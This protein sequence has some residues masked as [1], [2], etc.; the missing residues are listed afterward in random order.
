MPVDPEEQKK[1][2]Y[3]EYQQKFNMASAEYNAKIE[4]RTIQLMKYV[5]IGLYTLYVTMVDALTRPDS[6]F[7]LTIII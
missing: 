4:F 1:K 7:Y 2:I 6:D 3:K 5:S